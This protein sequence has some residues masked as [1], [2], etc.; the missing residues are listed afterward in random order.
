VEELE[1]GGSSTGAVQMR[2][3]APEEGA[4]IALASTEKS[5]SLPSVIVVAPGE[6]MATFVFTNYYKGRPKAVEIIATNGGSIARAELYV[7]SLPSDVPACSAHGC[8]IR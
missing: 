6:Q 3:P 8:V 1:A 2:D 7:P 5:L 4:E